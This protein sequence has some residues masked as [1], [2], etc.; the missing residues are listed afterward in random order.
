MDTQLDRTP[1]W[2]PKRATRPK[3][4]SASTRLLLLCCMVTTSLWHLPSPAG[5]QPDS[6]YPYD[7]ETSRLMGQF[8]H[9]TDIHPDEFYI[10][11]GSISTSCHRN[12]TDDDD[13]GMMRR[14]M[15]RP[16]RTEGGHGGLFGSPYSICDS[17]FSLA[18]ATFDWIDRNL[19]T[20]LDFVVWTGDN[21]RYVFILQ[22]QCSYFSANLILFVVFCGFD[23][24]QC[25]AI[26][27]DCI[28]TSEAELEQ[29]TKEERITEKKRESGC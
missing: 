27:M 22:L 5:A 10:N 29:L 11:G 7:P 18:N 2:R 16:G 12:T 17:P 21:A 23:L 13:D 19:I 1:P 20:S 8:L 28:K 25:L 4:R 15:L 9:I 14:M 26:R 24:E 3:R 6:P